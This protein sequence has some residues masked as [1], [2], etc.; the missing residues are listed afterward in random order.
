[1]IKSRPVLVWSVIVIVAA[2]L[3][4]TGYLWTRQQGSQE[5]TGVRERLRIGVT[6]DVGSALVIIAREKGFLQ[7]AGLDAEL[8]DYPS[9]ARSL[10]GMFAGDID[11]SM[12]VDVPI[13]LAGFARQDF[14]VFAT[15][16][17]ASTY[18]K[19]VARKD[20]GIQ[21]PKDLK[22]KHIA[23]Q[24][25][26]AVHY[27]L[28]LF[29]LNYGL[30]E[31]D[32]RLSFKKAEELS[33]ALAS[34]E[35]DA[36]SMREPFVSQAKKLL[37]D[38]ALVFDAPGLYESTCNLTASASLI[39]DR[40]EAIRRML[41]AVLRAEDFAENHPQ[42]ARRIVAKTLGITDSEVAAEWTKFGMKVSLSH[43]MLSGL[44]NGARWAM[45]SKLTDQ[46]A[47]PNFMELVYADG[48]RALRPE[49]VT[50]TTK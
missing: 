26:S 18:Q 28:H 13:L 21:S 8:K 11:V 5:F 49:A 12:P 45:S 22:G 42:E 4:A 15:I 37:G 47:I 35:I 6:L 41:K 48:L 38:N 27:F 25:S 31:K 24:K 17:S 10:E 36:F 40:P 30:S 19:I 16:S 14:R 20:R 7:Q 46:T 43:R 1:M 32:I 2:A 33:S 44:Q 29:L 50:I 3:L 34:G 39:K 9:G 23:T